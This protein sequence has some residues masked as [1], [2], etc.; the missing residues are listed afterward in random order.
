MGNTLLP[1]DYGEDNCSVCHGDGTSCLDC[2]AV[3]NGNKQ[4]DFCGHCLHPSD[5][6]FNKGNTYIFGDGVFFFKY[7]K[8]FQC[9]KTT[10]YRVILFNANN[11]KIA[12]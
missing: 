6:S 10:F 4:L 7:T 1:I 8:V 2:D 12:S 3:L 5:N 9:K 11:K